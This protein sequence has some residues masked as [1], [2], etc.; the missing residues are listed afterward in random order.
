L[1]LW[2][3]NLTT[4]LGWYGVAILC[5]A[6]CSAKYCRKVSLRGSV[7]LHRLWPSNVC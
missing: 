1:F 2:C 3:F 6:P 7:A 5:F 4:F